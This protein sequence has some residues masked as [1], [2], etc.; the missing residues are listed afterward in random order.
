MWHIFVY[1]C[2]FAIICNS[3]PFN[4]AAN[5]IFSGNG[6]QQTK[7]VPYIEVAMHLNLYI[8]C[9]TLNLSE[10][11]TGDAL[12]AEITFTTVCRSM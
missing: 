5:Y 3:L 4:F 2:M 7:Y 9:K 12:S 10:R 1:H 11:Q 6:K 8:H